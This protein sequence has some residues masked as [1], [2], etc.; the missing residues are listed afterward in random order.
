MVYGEKRRECVCVCVK[1]V[2][3]FTPLVVFINKDSGKGR[4]LRGLIVGLHLWVLHCSD[5]LG[6]SYNLGEALG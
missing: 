6:Q 4:S 1:S 3:L 2:P 5:P